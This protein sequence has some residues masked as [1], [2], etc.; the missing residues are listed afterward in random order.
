MVSCPAWQAELNPHATK[1]R[2]YR[3]WDI[4]AVVVVSELSAKGTWHIPSFCLNLLCAEL[5]TLVINCTSPGPCCFHSRL[6]SRTHLLPPRYRRQGTHRPRCFPSI[7]LRGWSS[8]WPATNA[9][10]LFPAEHEGQA[11]EA[12]ISFN[13]RLGCPNPTWRP[14]WQALQSTTE[15]LLV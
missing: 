6:M 3:H 1:S 10:C 13:T 8:V 7:S 4:L 12:H 15:Q 5:A 2:E 11:A 9:F 14:P